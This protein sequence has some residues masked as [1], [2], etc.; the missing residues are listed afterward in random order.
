MHLH[1]NPSK[2]I[3]HR[4][5]KNDRRKDWAK[6][7]DHKIKDSFS[8]ESTTFLQY[9]LFNLLCTNYSGYQKTGSNRCDRHHDR[10]RQEIKEI[11]E[12]HSDDLYKSK[13]SIAKRGKG[14]EHHHDNAH[15]NGR[16]FPSPFQLILESRNSTLGQR[17]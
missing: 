6:I 12:L 7:L 11:K 1:G 17:D 2:C 5:E 13:R 15:Y 9:F 4:T 8:A 14:T 3:C 10:V 16:F